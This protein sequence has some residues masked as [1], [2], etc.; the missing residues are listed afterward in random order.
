MINYIS[1]LTFPRRISQEIS[2][3][4]FI[5]QLHICHICK[6]WKKVRPQQLNHELKRVCKQ[7]GK[8][9]VIKR[10]S[11]MVAGH[12]ICWPLTTSMLVAMPCKVIDST[13]IWYVLQ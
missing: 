1:I 3:Q 6:Y 4:T 11:T 7:K 10:K 5:V 13:V 12:Q 8:V 2:Q 9:T